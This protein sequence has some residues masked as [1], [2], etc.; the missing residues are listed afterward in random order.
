MIVDYSSKMKKDL[1][2]LNNRV[3]F[4]RFNK[5]LQAMNASEDGS[6]NNMFGDHQLQG[7]MKAYRELHLDGDFLLVYKIHN[8]QIVRDGIF[9]HKELKK[10][11][12][13]LILFSF[14]QLH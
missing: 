3:A 5:V 1:K 4:K 14:L 2:K 7:S 12:G 13:A 10:K 8:N 9:S 6:I 11:Q